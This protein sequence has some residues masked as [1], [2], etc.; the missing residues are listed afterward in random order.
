M[1]EY[2]VVREYPNRLPIVWKVLTDPELVPLGKDR[3]LLIK[4]TMLDLIVSG[5]VA[6]VALLDRNW[7]L[8]PLYALLLLCTY[9]IVAILYEL[10]DDPVG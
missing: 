7:L 8:A 4:F 9:L 5:A 1:S 3:G 2:H 10:L 6:G